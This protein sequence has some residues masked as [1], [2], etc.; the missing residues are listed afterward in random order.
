MEKSDKKM[1]RQFGLILAGGFVVIF[2]LLLPWIWE[3]SYPVW[4]WVLAG[5]LSLIALSAPIVLKPLY[6]I[7][8][9]LG[10]VL[11]WVN[12]RIILGLVFFAVFFP[13]GIIMRLFGKDPMARDIM[14]GEESYRVPSKS[15]PPEQ[16]ERP[17]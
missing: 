8:M 5:A 14:S 13:F 2:G 1:L 16:M 11:G 7:W 12:T 3:H 17:F 15:S 10:H 6:H 9:K 4:P